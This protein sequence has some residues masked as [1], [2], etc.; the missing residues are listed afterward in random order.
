M[1]A[2]LDMPDLDMP[3]TLDSQPAIVKPVKIGEYYFIPIKSDDGYALV[4]A[5]GGPGRDINY[6]GKTVKL[7]CVMG[8]EEEVPY[9]AVSPEKGLPLLTYGKV[10]SKCA[11]EGRPHQDMY[12][13][14]KFAFAGR[15]FDHSRRRLGRISAKK[16]CSCPDRPKYMYTCVTCCP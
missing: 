9:D 13:D 5:F 14:N 12:N 10:C 2:N 4:D 3:G 1:G 11:D 7:V 16:W 6:D 8:H 15:R